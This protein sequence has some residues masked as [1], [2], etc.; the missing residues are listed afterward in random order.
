MS[1]YGTRTNFAAPAANDTGIHLKGSAT[2]RP[3]LCEFC[4][5]S[6]ATPV[7][8]TA[9]YQ[10]VRTTSAGTT[11]VA[12]LTVE[13]YDE[14]HPAAGTTAEGNGYTTEPSVGDIM[15]ET[16]VHQKNTFRWVAYPGREICNVVAANNGLGLVVISQSAV[17]SLN[18]S[19]VWIE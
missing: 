16:S 4:I 2:V 15:Y 12:T 5:S 18:L 6:D 7:E 11:P 10:V 19:A 8:Q 3:R 13:K 1:L 9:E 14:F 17:F